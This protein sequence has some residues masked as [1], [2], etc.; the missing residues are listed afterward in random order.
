MIDNSTLSPA[1]K[2]Q[3]I[4]NL[5]K[6]LTDKGEMGTLEQ[7]GI[8]ISNKINKF[9]ARKIEDPALELGSSIYASSNKAA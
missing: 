2:V 5:M 7:M 8:K 3:E 6:V 9:K 4:S 1:T